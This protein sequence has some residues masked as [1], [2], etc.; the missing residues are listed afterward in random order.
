MSQKAYVYFIQG[1]ETKRVK[2]G[3]GFNPEARL[4]SFQTGIHEP[5]VILGRCAC[6][7]VEDSKS[8]ESFL[9][10]KLKHLRIHGEW[11]TGGWEVLH[12]MVCHGALDGRKSPILMKMVEATM[13]ASRPF[14]EGFTPCTTASS[15]YAGA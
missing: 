11:F 15:S 7:S 9:H 6:E 3:R 12:Q 4:K 14:R 8:L 1:T 5:L 2:I 13:E 10:Q